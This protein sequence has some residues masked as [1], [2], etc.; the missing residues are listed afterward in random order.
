MQ[1][2]VELLKAALL[3]F[4]GGDA[5]VQLH[6]PQISEPAVIER[7]VKITPLT[8][9]SDVVE[10]S[11]STGLSPMAGNE[12][13]NRLRN[14]S[15]GVTARQIETLN[16]KNVISESDVE[17]HN[18]SKQLG[19]ETKLNTAPV[20]EEIQITSQDERPTNQNKY[21]P[22]TD[23]QVALGT[24]DG[25]FNL[26]SRYSDAYIAAVNSINP[27]TSFNL[28]PTSSLDLEKRID[29]ALLKVAPPA[30]N[31][32]FEL[33]SQKGRQVFYNWIEDSSASLICPFNNLSD[34]LSDESIYECLDI[35]GYAY[36]SIYNDKVTGLR[37]LE[38]G[39]QL[40]VGDFTYSEVLAKDLKLSDA[41]VNSI[42][43]QPL[44]RTLHINALE[45]IE[46][47]G[48]INNA[49]FNYFDTG[50]QIYE[51]Q[52]T[53][54]AGASS[55]AGGLSIT[56]SGNPRF[57]IGGRHFFSYKGLRYID[58]EVGLNS[59][60]EVDLSMDLLVDYSAISTTV[61]KVTSKP[62]EFEY[63]NV[64]RDGLEL[65][66]I[67]MPPVKGANTSKELSIG[68]SK[69]Q[70][71]IKDK[72]NVAANSSNEAQHLLSFGAA[73]LMEQTEVVPGEIKASG[74][75]FVSIDSA[76]KAFV[77]AKARYESKP[78]S[79]IPDELFIQIKAGADVIIGKLDDVPLDERLYLGGSETV[80]GISGN[81]VGSTTDVFKSGGNKRVYSQFEVFKPVTI[82]EKRLSVGAHLDVGYLGGG[83]QNIS[84]SRSSLGVFTKMDISNKAHLYG[85]F[86]IPNDSDGR[87]S[88]GLSVATK[89]K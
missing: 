5:V 42:V 81:Y 51:A 41:F 35:L 67:D 23:D 28:Q 56:G 34:D 68:V 45:R 31:Y 70:A 73:L 39:S 20:S 74:E 63:F 83:E 78:Y 16:V 36:A 66:R 54:D 30:Q 8:H 37:T 11:Y 50:D 9:F 10:A 48:F 25:Y 52:L 22:I 43:G 87:A 55:I 65:R 53:G 14:M 15:S 44:S 64:R 57:K 69:H 26:E 84:D 82:M 86:S 29:E 2:A 3:L 76:K 18:R 61:M 13:A 47:L 21:Q 77:K 89:F 32:I 33:S 80:R 58:Y 19:V 72:V 85:Y 12:I 46:K 4:D 59:G 17:A 88:I 60:N 79:I 71:L 6:L 27:I 40:R 1:L 62:K 49:G 38:T 75:A 7:S 24:T